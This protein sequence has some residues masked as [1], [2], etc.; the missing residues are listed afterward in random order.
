MSVVP[1][2]AF[3][4]GTPG[5]GGGGGGGEEETT[6]NSLSVPAI[7]V[8]GMLNTN[9]NCNGEAVAPT[10]T[11]QTGFTG[12]NI[13]PLAYFYVQGVHTWQASCLP[14]ESATGVAAAWGDN[15]TGDAKLKVGSPIRVEIGLDVGAVA[16]MTGWEVVKLDLALDRL[17][18]YGTQATAIEGDGWASNP[19]TP[20]PETRVW[21]AG[22]WLTIYPLSD[23]AS[24]V[25][26]EAATAEINS[27]GRVV[28]GYNLRVTSLGKYMIEYTFP[29][30]EVE[31]VN[32]PAST[33]DFDTE[34]GTTVVRLPIEVIGGGG[35]GGGGGRR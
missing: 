10:G 15:L 13:D 14:A 27:T 9:L 20:Y 3:A 33:F 19:T 31:S 26:N 28:Y 1:G 22:T 30:V 7:F 23:E 2:A 18:R 11:P 12:E 5:G 16:D 8:G 21:T 32:K 35:G 34:T 29:K 17:S 25:V 24:P 4:K 6:T